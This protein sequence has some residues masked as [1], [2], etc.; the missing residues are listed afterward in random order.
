[1]TSFPHAGHFP[2][3]EHPSKPWEIGALCH[4]MDSQK[5]G[6]LTKWEMISGMTRNSIIPMTP[7]IL[8]W[9][10]IFSFMM[11]VSPPINTCTMDIMAMMGCNFFMWSAR[12]GM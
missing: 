3:M 4:P 1:M 6:L 12:M 2:F 8:I 11:H 10:P 7:A 9:V 5:Y